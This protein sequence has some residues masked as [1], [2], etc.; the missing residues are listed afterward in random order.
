MSFI[1][2]RRKGTRCREG[3]I[4]NHKWSSSILSF[5]KEE[6]KKGKQHPFQRAEG[7][8]ARQ[9]LWPRLRWPTR[10]LPTQ[11]AAV[12]AQCPDASPGFQS[13]FYHPAY[14]M[15]TQLPSPLKPTAAQIFLSNPPLPLD[16]LTLNPLSVNCLGG[17]ESM[18]YFGHHPQRSPSSPLH[19]AQPVLNS[20][21]DHSYPH[22]FYPQC[23]KQILQ[24]EHS[25]PHQPAAPSLQLP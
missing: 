18:S 2:R 13:P 12:M 20:P 22:C 7:E 25:G 15:L 17:V 23:S 6:R 16:E 21:S 11:R 5:Q 8:A 24:I 14:Y 1:W 9:L 3:K 19:S 4:V 10:R